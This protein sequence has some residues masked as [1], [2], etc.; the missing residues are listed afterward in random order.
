M[1]INVSPRDILDVVKDLKLIHSL[2]KKNDGL[3]NKLTHF[4]Q[5]LGK[6]H[7]SGH[8]KK[9]LLKKLLN[10]A[11]LAFLIIQL[12][13]CLLLAIIN[14]N[15]NFHV[16]GN[17][18]NLDHLLKHFI[19]GY[20]NESLLQGGYR[21]PAGSF[22]TDSE[23]NEIKRIILT[24]AEQKYQKNKIDNRTERR[25]I[26]DGTTPRFGR[27]KR[28]ENYYEDQIDDYLSQFEK[29]DASKIRR[30]LKRRSRGFGFDDY[31]YDGNNNNNFRYNYD[32]LDRNYSSKLL[33]R[34]LA[35]QQAL[36]L[37]K[38]QLTA[39]IQRKELEAKQL[40]SQLEI[41]EKQLAEV[42]AQTTTTGST[43]ASTTAS[44]TTSTGAV[45]TTAT[46]PSTTQSTTQCAQTITPTSSN[47]L[48]SILSKSAVVSL[49]KTPNQPARASSLLF[50]PV[51]NR[52]R[53]AQ[54][55]AILPSTP[56][57][58]VVASTPAATVVAS[59]PAATVVGAPS[60][61]VSTPASGTSTALAT[62][63]NTSVVTSLGLLNTLEPI[64]LQKI[65]D[66]NIPVV[67]A[68][69]GGYKQDSSLNNSQ[70]SLE[71]QYFKYTIIKERVSA[72]LDVLIKYTQM[73]YLDKTPTQ[74]AAV[75]GISPTTRR[76]VVT[77]N[78]ENRPADENAIDVANN[79]I[80]ETPYEFIT[81]TRPGNRVL[82]YRTITP[83]DQ[84]REVKDKIAKLSTNIINI[85][86]AF[87]A[88]IDKKIGDI[89]T[90]IGSNFGLSTSI[91]TD[92][93]ES[94]KKK[95]EFLKKYPNPELSSDTYK[96]AV[97]ARNLIIEELIPSFREEPP[98]ELA[99]Y[100]YIAINETCRILINYIRE[101]TSELQNNPP[102][103]IALQEILYYYQLRI[104][105]QT[106]YL[107]NSYNS[108]LTAYPN[109][110]TTLDRFTSSFMYILNFFNLVN[111][112]LNRY[113]TDLPEGA[114]AYNSQSLSQEVQK[115]SYQ[116]S[117]TSTLKQLAPEAVDMQ[118]ERFLYN[119]SEYAKDYAD[120]I[121]GM[122]QT[123]P[124][125]L[126][127]PS[128]IT[129]NLN[130]LKN[131][132]NRYEGRLLTTASKLADTNKNIQQLDDY[133]ILIEKFIFY[134]WYN[135]SMPLAAS[136]D[137]FTQN[138]ALYNQLIALPDAIG[139]T[140]PS[141]VVYDYDLN[142]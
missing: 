39:A 32:I 17:N 59:T 15:P 97:Q 5:F 82:R 107:N 75:M 58:T 73:I 102:N 100:E 52:S 3:E 74:V 141:T 67:K 88:D 23:I 68:V 93:E 29:D 133:L 124:A 34:K 117:Q 76:A 16:D 20:S 57:A 106:F 27:K 123:N 69:Y 80:E 98:I 142:F 33:H 45:S 89:Q 108:L 12:K 51:A 47:T 43:T 120:V 30:A 85:K 99:G 87:I 8:Y 14:V 112:A 56:A 36:T 11:Q 25:L 114:K 119:L 53:V 44:T 22:I 7:S 95:K 103:T 18:Y 128:I 71:D 28:F 86:N 19:R 125:L 48:R 10:N 60:V 1:G 140:R 49:P 26:R 118:N 4:R 77:V 61:V 31:N 84:S 70:L 35:Q 66:T 62:I 134:Y 115:I 126:P 110:K 122:A 105:F 83:T 55:S 42:T 24:L 129:A 131:K 6:N 38:N 96:L 137:L 50:T 72:L 127:I 94:S 81:A 9:C 13:D 40:K 90:K 79:P 135:R 91:I 116:P 21:Y 113:I 138:A 104:M 65:V 132:L 41:I 78:A 101:L 111:I 121:K 130:E 2:K 46:T 54:V 92:T 64:K 139:K 37:K 63:A 136:E 109:N